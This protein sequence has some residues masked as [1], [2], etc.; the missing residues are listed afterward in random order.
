MGTELTKF[1]RED[2]QFRSFRECNGGI[3]QAVEICQEDGDA[4]KVD[5]GS[6]GLSKNIY[7]QVNSVIINV[8]TL[9]VSYTVPVGKKFD[10]SAATCSGDNI[11]RFIVKVNSQ[12]IQAKRTWFTNF[13]VDFDFQELILNETDKVEIFV[14]NNGKSSEDFEATIIGGEYNG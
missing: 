1:T 5:I 13:N 8:E 2:R 7:N 10:L 4:I 12:V 6:R 3:V 9:V 11:A 14:E